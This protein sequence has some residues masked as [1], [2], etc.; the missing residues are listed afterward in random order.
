M[1]MY[2]LSQPHNKTRNERNKNFN[3]HKHSACQHRR[4]NEKKAGRPNTN[5]TAK[6]PMIRT[7][8][9]TEKQNN[10]NNTARAPDAAQ[11]SE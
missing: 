8:R 4:S 6:K 10:G 7:D 2:K 9:Q 3:V 11:K 5:K 1:Y